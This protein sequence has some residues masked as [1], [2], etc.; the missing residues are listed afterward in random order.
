MI[1]NPFQLAD[2]IRAK[3]FIPNPGNI[4][5]WKFSFNCFELVHVSF[6]F[7]AGQGNKRTS[8][9]LPFLSIMLGHLAAPYI[10]ALPSFPKWCAQARVSNGA[11]IASNVHKLG[12][13]ENSVQKTDARQPSY[14]NE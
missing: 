10:Q 12:V 1:G 5:I 14:L 3:T 7:D 4:D 13:R 2:R 9:L 11:T 8:M 6:P